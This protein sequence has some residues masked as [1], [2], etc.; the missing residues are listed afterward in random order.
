[1]LTLW[2]YRDIIYG[3]GGNDI[4][5]GDKGGD[6]L[7]GGSG[8]DT[9]KYYKPSDSFIEHPDSIMDFNQF[10]GD[11]IDLHDIAL[12]IGHDLFV[13]PND[14]N[15]YG[16]GAVTGTGEYKTEN[17]YGMNIYI[18]TDASGPTMDLF[19]NFVSGHLMPG[20]VIF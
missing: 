4:I 12:A 3:G 13:A 19:V 16:I 15:N 17:G 14:G 10:E 5:A 7:Y 11:K 6:Q 18:N 20:T 1:M 2:Y 8:A 9:F